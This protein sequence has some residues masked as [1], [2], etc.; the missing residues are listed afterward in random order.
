MLRALKLYLGLAI[1]E[2]NQAVGDIL[3]PA[4]AYMSV[5]RYYAHCVCVRVCVLVRA[6]MC[7][8]V[9]ARTRA[10][11]CVYVCVRVCVPVRARVVCV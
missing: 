10:R 7:A 1:H 2:I 9:R 11:V 5:R 6:L 4:A 8:C 3:L